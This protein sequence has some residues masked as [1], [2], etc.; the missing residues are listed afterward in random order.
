MVAG[1]N[2]CCTASMQGA[3][4][5]LVKVGAEGVFIAVAI[6]AGVVIA[7]KADDGASRAAEVMLGAALRQLGLLSGGQYDALSRWYKPPIVNSQQVV[8][9]S[10]RPSVIWSTL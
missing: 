3:D 7:L 4:N 5:L 8:V 6:E 9:G 10:I 1:S 2:R